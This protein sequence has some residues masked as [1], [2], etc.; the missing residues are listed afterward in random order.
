MLSWDSIARERR[1]EALD[2]LVPARLIQES[3]MK[4]RP[5]RPGLRLPDRESESARRRK[6]KKEGGRT[7]AASEPMRR[8]KERERERERENE[9]NK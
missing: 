1:E 7:R 9:N 4:W 8:K 6:R 5:A 3:D 2:S